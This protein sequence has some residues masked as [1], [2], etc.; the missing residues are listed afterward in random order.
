MNRTLEK[1]VPQVAPEPFGRPYCVTE[2]LR[3]SGATIR[4]FGFSLAQEPDPTYFGQ[5]HRMQALETEL[6]KLRVENSAMRA[7]LDVID[8]TLM[9]VRRVQP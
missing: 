2:D 6:Q 3:E 5:A 1:A 4:R 7:A 8:R 9:T